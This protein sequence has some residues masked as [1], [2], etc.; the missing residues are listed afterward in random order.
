MDE[1]AANRATS[2]SGLDD[3]VVCPECHELWLEQFAPEFC[4]RCGTRV[5]AVAGEGFGR[6]RIE[7]TKRAGL[8]HQIVTCHNCGL[9]YPGL[10]K[11]Q[12]CF[13]CRTL[14]Q[15]AKKPSLLRRILRRFC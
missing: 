4:H 10:P 11:P 3:A 15:P 7:I 14:L 8:G 5:A 9:R 13:R 1:T 2:I 12:P 6:L